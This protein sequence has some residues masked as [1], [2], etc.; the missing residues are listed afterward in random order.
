MKRIETVVRPEKL[1][2][3]KE[4]LNQI[5]IRGITIT[6]VL[7]CGNQLGWKES[8]RGNDTLLTILPKIMLIL[9]IADDKLEETINTIIQVAQ[10]GE[11]GDGKIFVS[12][13][14]ECIRIRTGER[15]DAA[16]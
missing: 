3:L 6:P 16:I 7:G 2:S 5:Q 12:D 14:E 15:G 13:I 1:E 9:I 8:V 4:A 10:T 11:V